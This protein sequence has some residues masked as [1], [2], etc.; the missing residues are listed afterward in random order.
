MSDWV[1]LEEF[2]A[3]FKLFD[4]PLS[5]ANAIVRWIEEKATLARISKQAEFDL[6]ENLAANVE[7]LFWI[8][9]HDPQKSQETGTERFSFVDGFQNRLLC[10]SK[11]T[12]L[13]YRWAR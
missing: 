5:F 3:E 8:G 6:V 13:G 4:E 12:S 11:S 10:L 2:N 1:C 7:S 9:I